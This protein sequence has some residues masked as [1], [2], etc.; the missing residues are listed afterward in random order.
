MVPHV[1][2]RKMH[3]GSKNFRSSSQKDFCNNIGQLQTCRCNALT[4]V[5]R[6]YINRDDRMLDF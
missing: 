4:D 1:A 2:A 6:T 3:S 5:P